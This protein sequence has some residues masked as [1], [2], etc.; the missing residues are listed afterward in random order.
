MGFVKVN[1]KL[2]IHVRS[3]SLFHLF[4]NF[5][6]NLR[7]PYQSLYLKS[8]MSNTLNFMIRGHIP[9]LSLTHLLITN[10]LSSGTLQ[11]THIFR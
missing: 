5:V 7:K 3:F 1:A 2:Y 4:G 8:N 11:L 6:Q 10:S 9:L